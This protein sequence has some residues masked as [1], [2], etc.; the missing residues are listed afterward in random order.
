MHKSEISVTSILVEELRE[1]VASK[2]R[3]HKWELE[4][5]QDN[6]MYHTK[7]QNLMMGENQVILEKI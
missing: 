2:S 3:E 1:E 6:N 4:E 5:L 7:K